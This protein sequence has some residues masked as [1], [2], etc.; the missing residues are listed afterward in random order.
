MLYLSFPITV[1]DRRAITTH[2][3][4]IVTNSFIWIP[5]TEMTRKYALLLYTT[6]LNIQHDVGCDTDLYIMKNIFYEY[7]KLR[8]VIQYGIKNMIFYTVN[9][10]FFSFVFFL[11]KFH[12]EYQCLTNCFFFQYPNCYDLLLWRKNLIEFHI[13]QHVFWQKNLLECYFT[14]HNAINW[15]KNTMDR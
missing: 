12:T 3:E 4:S 7:D 2:W 11:P 8:Y 1:Y 13:V 10:E 9:C 6:V 15:L 5:H 14:V